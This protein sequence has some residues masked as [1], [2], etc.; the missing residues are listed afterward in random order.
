[1]RPSIARIA[2]A[3]AAAALLGGC[4]VGWDSDAVKGSGNKI[5]Q[6]RDLPN[7]EKIVLTGAAKL[8]VQ[9][10]ASQKVVIEADDNIV[11]LI[12]TE[13]QGG[14][15]REA[16]G[17][18]REV[19]FVD[20]T[21][22]H[23]VLAAD[24]PEVRFA[25]SPGADQGDVQ[26][27][28]GRVGPEQPRAGQDQDARARCGRRLEEMTPFHDAFRLRSRCF[29]RFGCCLARERKDV[30]GGRQRKKLLVCRPLWLIHGVGNHDG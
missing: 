15:L 7:F 27:V 30:A 17:A 11:P 25:A 14:V 29:Y 13:V 16:L 28:A 12:E 6:A 1:M 19:F 23:D 24:G 10:G 20:V 18:E 21:E 8:E 26:F 5:E 9:A 4:F 2:L 22:G 3:I